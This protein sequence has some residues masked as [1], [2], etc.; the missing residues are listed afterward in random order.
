[1]SLIIALPAAKAC[2]EGFSALARL[3]TQLLAAHPQ[4]LVLDCA[5]LTWLD[6]HLC[7]PLA[8]ILASAAARLQPVQQFINLDS[9]VQ[10]SLCRSGLLTQY[11][12]NIVPDRFNTA[13]PLAQFRN[14]DVR[15]YEQAQTWVS[16]EK[17]PTMTP[18]ARRVLA[19]SL[20]ELF[21][22]AQEHAESPLGAYT[23]GQ[24][25]PKQNRL[26]F[27]LSDAGIGIPN[28][29]RSL[30]SN[31]AM[32]DTESLRWALA[33][34]ST[35]RDLPGGSGLQVVK[36]FVKMNGGCLQIV[37]GGVFY[38]Y[39]RYVEAYSALAGFALGTTIALEVNTADSSFY[40]V[41]G[42]QNSDAHTGQTDG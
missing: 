39:N 3:H 10:G 27:S 30:A 17:L 41:T 22:N 32:S 11:G 23:C 42:E 31:A 28:R 34:N 14:G 18:Q 24:F 40:C 29:V 15:F 13:V 25:F 8:A 21:G 9:T 1:M 5:G 7:A 35:R 36:S 4:P 33:G 37:T 26:R 2:H 6:A 12:Y 38:E 20:G 16:H 19:D